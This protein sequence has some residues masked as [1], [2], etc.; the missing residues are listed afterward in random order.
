MRF[1]EAIIGELRH[2]VEDFG[3]LRRINASFDGALREAIALRLH[4]RRDLLAHRPAQQVGRSQ[5][6]ARHR[7]GY[8]H[9]LF[10]VNH[11]PV[12]LGQDVMNDRMRGLPFFPMLAA[13]VIRDV[14]HGPRA[15]EGDG[16][17]EVLEAVGAHLAQRIAH[18]LAFHLEHPASLPAREHLIAFFI[19]QRQMIQIDGYPKF[20]QKS[21][22]A[23]KNGQ[24]GQAE[25]VEFHQTGLL[26]IFHR[27][28]R[29]QKVRLRILIKRHQINQRPVADD[30]AGGMGR[31]VA[32]QTLDLQGDFQQAGN[33]F[34]VVAEFL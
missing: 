14:C 11:D 13:A 26:D 29:D 12:G 7:L 6:I 27:V 17:D 10:L 15:I 25:K 31:C 28:L 4:F 22:G 30:H 24:R 33:A 5:R 34:I 1:I 32:V 18:A 20:R 2:E 8:L 3:G 9:D 21:L 16:G 23:I 19:V